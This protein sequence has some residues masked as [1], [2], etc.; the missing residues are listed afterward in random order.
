MLDRRPG[1]YVAKT[2]IGIP[3]QALARSNNGMPVTR[4][5]H[6]SGISRGTKDDQKAQ[7]QD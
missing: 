2:R 5:M 7:G 4:V 3:D 1:R 6:R